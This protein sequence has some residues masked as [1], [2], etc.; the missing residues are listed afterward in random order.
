MKRLPVIATVIVALAV[1]AMVALGVWQLQRA[2]EKTAL[3][4]RLSA[5][6]SLPPRAYPVLGPVADDALFRKS[7]VMCL[8][9]KAWRTEGGGGGYRHIAECAT[10][11]VEGPGALIDMGV[12]NDPAVKP[13]WTG[14]LVNGTIATE[15]DRTSVI[16]RL[17]PRATPLRPMLIAAVPAPGLRASAVP[18]AA[19]LPN[20]HF[21][22]AIQWF[23]FAVVAV[24]VFG[25]ALRQR[26]KGSIPQTPRT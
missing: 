6:A 18:T 26:A 8:S 13:S 10:A 5:N 16:G 22:Y 1:A 15:P 2:D 21:G 24:G 12:S 23:L 4:A 3:I 14:G 17:F 7:S 11:G 19:G 25:I 20:N 9:V